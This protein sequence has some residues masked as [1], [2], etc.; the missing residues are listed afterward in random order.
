MMKID[1]NHNHKETEQWNTEVIQE[2]QGEETGLE[3][4][5]AKEK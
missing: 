2:N 4:I 5:A 3:E 1:R